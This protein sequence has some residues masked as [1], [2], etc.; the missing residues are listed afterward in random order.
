M[1]ARIHIGSSK[2]RLRRAKLKS[3]TA[4]VGHTL[5]ELLVVVLMTVIL[6]MGLSKAVS[7]ALAL[8]QNYRE[9]AEVR[10]RL[11]AYA[12]FYEKNISLAASV[13]TNAEVVWTNFVDGAKV[14]V[15]NHDGVGTS[16]RMETGG[17][18]LEAG[19]I[20]RVSSW[21]GVV[22]TN[23]NTYEVLISGDPQ[24]GGTNVQQGT[25][26]S[27]KSPR[28]QTNQF[29][30][31][32]VEGTQSVRRLRLSAKVPFWTYTTNELGVRGKY[33][34]TNEVSVERPVRLW[35]GT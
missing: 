32:V 21:T 26:L 14:V 2:Y 3:G 33:I 24:R 13:I 35:N 11:S 5:V 22:I 19:R 15:T 23:G 8:E 29:V 9:E 10:T 1:H 6:A 31:F 7:A 12:A 4:V 18:S 25:L 20:I 28:L 30:R 17:V 16:Y 27:E 34:R